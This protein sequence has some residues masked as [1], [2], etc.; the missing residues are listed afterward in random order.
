M[1]F[2]DTALDMS[3]NSS[4]C[5]AML[6]RAEAT[7]ANKANKEL[8]V[9]LEMWTQIICRQVQKEGSPILSELAS[10]ALVA[11]SAIESDL[12]Y[13]F[14]LKS[15]LIGLSKLFEFEPE[16]YK[17]EH[18]FFIES[19]VSIIDRLDVSDIEG[20]QKTPAQMTSR[21]NKRS[22]SCVSRSPSPSIPS[23]S[24]KSSTPI[25]WIKKM[26][27]KKFSTTFD[28]SFDDDKGE[29]SG[30]A[31]FFENILTKI[32]NDIK[33]RNEIDEEL[34]NN[35]NNNND[36]MPISS[37]LYLD[38]DKMIKRLQSQKRDITKDFICGA[39]F[40]ERD[41]IGY[42]FG[43]SQV[44][45]ASKYEQEN[46]GGTQKKD[47]DSH[48]LGVWVHDEFRCQKLGT[49]LVNWFCDQ[50]PYIAAEK[51]SGEA[52]SAKIYVDISQHAVK[53]WKSLGENEKNERNVDGR[54]SGWIVSEH[55]G[56]KE[57]SLQAH[58]D[59]VQD[60]E[61]GERDSSESS[62]A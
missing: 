59:D 13:S 17:D 7:E 1:E 3:T 29:K 43:N 5:Q 48:L 21:A 51:L 16:T 33:L 50:L 46:S 14:A 28:D 36:N 12:V 60:A 62:K 31:R 2:G 32:K 24:A 45:S 54:R 10:C 55:N 52:R 18:K 53:F 58:H 39:I 37:N 9:T 11:L 42:V 47:F 61:F 27:F 38:R 8:L 20:T 35:N 56:S 23:K 57:I 22:V 6:K 41:L 4:T 34:K 26:T 25:L 49:K 44:A 30:I 19:A 15:A 40:H